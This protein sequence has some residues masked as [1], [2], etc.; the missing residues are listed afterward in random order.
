MVFMYTNG[1]MA[2]NITF[3]GRK[4]ELKL[5]HSAFNELRKLLGMNKRYL[6]T[7]ALLWIVKDR[8]ARAEFIKYI[9]KEKEKIAKD[10]IK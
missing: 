2:S 6:Y 4:D 3:V 9:Q 5:I 7:K 8:K 1:F 10:I